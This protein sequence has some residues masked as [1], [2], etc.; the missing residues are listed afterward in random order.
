MTLLDLLFPPFCLGCGKWGKY[1]CYDCLVKIKPLELQKC[2]V[3]NK[4]AIN[5]MTHPNCLKTNTIDG[6]VAAFSYNGVIRKV[7][8]KLK[9]Q[10]VFDLSQT[11]ARLTVASLK[12]NYSFLP[13]FQE[14]D[15]I[16]I[17]APLFKKRYNWRG[18]NQAETVGSEVA[19]LLKLP[20]CNDIL[21]RN[22]STIPQAELGRERRLKNLRDVFSLN[23]NS[24][25]IIRNSK[26]ILFDDVSTTGATLCECAKVLKKAGVIKVWGITIAR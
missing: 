3:C 14:K 21:I 11:L 22:R 24:K 23:P 18:F 6:S 16:L 26:F 2:A 20:I 13:I 5:G 19:K 10:F 15:W 12:K 9:Y 1:I 7:I 4:P 17:P 25:F 8:T